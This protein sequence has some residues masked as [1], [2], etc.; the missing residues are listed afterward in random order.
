MRTRDGRREAAD[1]FT[2]EPDVVQ[3]EIVLE[4]RRGGRTVAR[5]VGVGGS[6]TTGRV[7]GEGGCARNSYAKREAGSGERRTTAWVN[8]GPYYTSR[9]FTNSVE[10]GLRL[11]SGTSKKFVGDVRTDRNNSTRNAEMQRIQLEL[12]VPYLNLKWVIVSGGGMLRSETP[13]TKSKRGEPE[14][15]GISE[16][17]E[18][19]GCTRN[20][21]QLREEMA[22]RG[23]C[24]VYEHPE[25]KGPI[26][27]S[28]KGGQQ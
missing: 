7:R 18:I 8:I 17:V 15:T 27:E 19:V 22:S 26:H 1:E 12:E 24:S 6:G 20:R 11:T 4:R 5:T 14:I 25:Y 16:A 23:S 21:E 28:Q 3:E 10:D 2:C 13:P 9:Q